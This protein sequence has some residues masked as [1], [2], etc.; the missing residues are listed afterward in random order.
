VTE[1]KHAEALRLANSYNRSLIEASLDPLVTIGPDG[2]ITDVNWATESATGCTRETLIGTDFSD[3]FTEP[4]KAQAGYQQVFREGAVRDYPLELRRRDGHVTSVL[5]NASVYRDETGNPVGVFAAARDITERKRA[6]A[7]LKETNETLERR[8]AERTAQLSASEERLR[9]LNERLEQQVNE[10][11]EALAQTIDQL[12]GEVRR[13]TVIEKEL[14]R[15][16]Q[17][18]EG[19]FQHTITPLAFLD[20]D[21]NFIRV[22]DAYA[23]ADKRQPQEFIG[24]NHFD[25]YRNKESREIFEDVV[26]TKEPFHAYSRPL[27]YPRH[28]RRTTYWNWLLTPLLDN[29]GEVQSLVLNLKDV[30]DRQKAFEELERRASQLQRLTLELSQAEDRERQRLA[31]IL[32]DDL[33]QLL[34]GAKFHLNTVTRKI[35]G[36]DEVKKMLT[37]VYD[38]ISESIEKS[39]GLSHELTPPLLYQG[40]LGD[41]LVWLGRQMRQTC[42]LTVEVDAA[43]D[44][45]LSSDPLKAFMYKAA[46]ELLFNVVKHAQVKEAR[47]QLR[48]L[49][50]YVRLIVSDEGKGFDPD[51]VSN[52]GGFGLFSI[53]ERARLLGGWM[54][55]KSA[56]AQPGSPKSGSGSVFILAI[57]DNQKTE[58]REQK[59]EDSEVLRSPSSDIRPPTAGHPLRVML[60][61]DHKV[62]REGVAILLNEQPDI[63]VIGQA[64]NGREA[65]SMARRLQP[66]VIIMDVAMPIMGGEEATRK[67]KT[68]LPQTRIIGLSLSEEAAVAHK[69]KRAGAERYISKADPS[70]TLLAAIRGQL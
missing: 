25:F 1:R 15:R 19:F 36:S 14:H 67:I 45:D 46:Q 69:M 59:A 43:S 40:T 52:T 13:R 44:I 64:G 48:R 66:D 7:A 50:G 49:K 39:R 60:V 20:K 21:F 61:D 63:E 18:L 70:E 31:E 57:P 62:M 54:K 24:R 41:A 34:V 37:Q 29:A 32:H 35:K 12:E 23:R 4:D 30:T 65:V 51:T 53:Q 8:V 16:S 3:Y 2:K 28:P 17:M 55:F 9:L 22:N 10:R 56:S 47:L 26:R 42:G 5:Y 58:D 27:G 11:T 6:E 33:Q 68:H 38:L